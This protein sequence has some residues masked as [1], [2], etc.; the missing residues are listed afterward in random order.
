MRFLYL[1]MEFEKAL[2]ARRGVIREMLP[3]HIIQL[4][5]CVRGIVSCI[6][7]MQRTRTNARSIRRELLCWNQKIACNN[8]V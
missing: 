6:Q 5:V 7:L 3:R 2:R 1:L 4:V 8:M